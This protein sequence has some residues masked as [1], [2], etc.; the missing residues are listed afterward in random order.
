MVAPVPLPG[1]SGT[2]MAERRTEFADS[3]G[4]PRATAN[5][6][7]RAEERLR[8]NPYLAL[9]N[10]SCE[11]R[12][13]VLTLRGCLPSYYLRQVAQAAVSGME[14]VQ[15]V[16]DCIEVVPPPTREGRIEARPRH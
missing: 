8:S 11:Y 4:A 2:A 9:K 1:E 6:S 5:V 3:P 14:G 10:V 12:D 15:S 16:I 13:G 7:E